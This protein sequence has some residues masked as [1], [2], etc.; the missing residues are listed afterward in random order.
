M[1]GSTEKHI[2]G[3]SG[4]SSPSIMYG[5]SCVVMP[6]P[7]PVRWMNCSP[8][9][10]SVITCRAARSISWQATPGPDRLDAGLLR[11][12]D[13]LVHLADLGGRL[14]DAHGAAGVRAVAVHQAAE[15]EDD[16]V[17]VLDGPVAGL[18]VRVGAVRARSRPR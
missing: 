16:R 2:P 6:M 13:D 18:V 7:W 17:A 4:C 12:P 14:A 8:Y 1:P 15:V 3:T 9:P 10:A 11:L 5:G